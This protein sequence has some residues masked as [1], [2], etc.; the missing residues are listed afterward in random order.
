M[1]VFDFPLVKLTI[2]L[3]IGIVIGAI[4]NVS[5]K[6]SL[7][8]T[9]SLLVLLLIAYLFSRHTF[10]KT[11]W[12]GLAG[13]MTM[14]SVGIATLNFHNELIYKQHYTHNYELKSSEIH[15]I[16]LEITEALKSNS[17]YNRYYAEVITINSSK[18]I[19]KLL[20]NIKKDSLSIP[21]QVDTQLLLKAKLQELYPPLNPH[22]FDYKAYLNNHDIYA[23]VYT[24]TN[25]LII[26]N[27]EMHSIYGYADNIR[28]TIIS[29]LEN[30]SF[31]PDEL[32][33]IK[34]LLLGQRQ[35]ISNELRQKYINAGAI[36]ILA[37][38]GFEST[39]VTFI[40]VV[41]TEASH[42]SSL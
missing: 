3:I 12:F 15:A 16:Q 25:N 23:Q 9:G 13:Y 7:V 8:T 10:K 17:S 4:Y 18:A 28:Q 21:L 2:C 14:I 38:S 5:L 33:I 27:T 36:H 26:E 34:A 35:D 24:D 29:R 20:L 31:K 1:K 11:I 22:Q 6:V 39:S 41:R 32:A 42:C 37:I 19:G 30:Y 40:S